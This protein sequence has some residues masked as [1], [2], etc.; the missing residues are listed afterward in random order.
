MSDNQIFSINYWVEGDNDYFAADWYGKWTYS[1]KEYGLGHAWNFFDEFP[2]HAYKAVLNAFELPEKDYP[3]EKI[4]KM[5][6]KELALASGKNI[7][8]YTLGDHRTASEVD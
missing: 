7:E 8:S 3:L 1:C 4:A 5:S 2:R 6:P